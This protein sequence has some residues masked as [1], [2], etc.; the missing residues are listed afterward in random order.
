MQKVWKDSMNIKSE[1]RK[2]MLQEILGSM[3]KL[4]PGFYY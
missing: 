2:V 3:E 4:I 1:T